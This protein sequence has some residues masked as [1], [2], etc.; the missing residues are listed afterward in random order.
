MDFRVLGPLEVWTDGRR[1]ELGGP[2]Q[3]ALL[4]LLLLNANRVVSRDRLLEELWG[5]EG[6]AGGRHALNVTVARLRK[7]L[8]GGNGRLLSRPPGYVLRVERDEL[9]LERFEQLVDDG[10]REL[11]A[12]DAARA[13]ATL[14]EAESLWRGRPLADLEFEPF[15]RVDVD[16]LEEL[17]LGAVE[18]R[19]DAEVELGRHAALVP[20]LE[21]LVAE[22]PLRE[23]L[24]AQLMLAL[25]ASARQADAL[26]VYAD[27]RR[28]LVDE[29]GIEPS[30]PLREL[31][32]RVLVQDP[33]LTP[34]AQSRWPSA[35]PRPRPARYPRRYLIALGALLPA[36]A[37]AIV[38]TQGRTDRR[39]SPLVLKGGAMVLVDERSG[40]ARLLPTGPDAGAVRYGEG[41]FWKL[42]DVG[43]VLRI[44]PRGFR[45][46]QSIPVR[47]S[48]GGIAIGDGSVWVG[49]RSQTL[50]RIDPRYGTVAQR[51]RLRGS[52]TGTPVAVAFGA[53][54]V[55]VAQGRSRVLRLDPATGRVEARFPVAN[56]QVLAFGDG[57]LWVA[58][59]DLGT[60]TKI[61]PAT[62]TIAATARVGP[63]ICCLTVG[64]G[65]VWATNDTGL[66]KISDAGEPVAT[67]KLA[68]EAGDVAYGDGALW[69]TVMDQLLRIGL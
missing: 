10:R 45:L 51:I 33:D 30:E 44:D 21:A 19:I 40:G 6:A 60:L 35:P 49:E 25:Y 17:R 55:W 42:D 38:L 31:Q 41:S 67:I 20:E 68:N 11:V 57:A 5:E 48:G 13:A 47:P 54:S 7:A 64:G 69:V 1:L 36:A 56:A 34:A 14:R 8:G 29:L 23:R 37:L 32:R 63:W 27:A 16:R 18:D 26:A 52:R 3:R 12:G 58:A 46:T 9:D 66:W 4:A 15:V 61:D 39:P 50:A 28:R 22:H 65:Y 24:R 62:N 43:Q 53:G 59:S 2:R